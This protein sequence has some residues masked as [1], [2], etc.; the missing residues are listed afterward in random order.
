M[1]RYDAMLQEYPLIHLCPCCNELGLNLQPAAF[2]FSTTVAYPLQARFPCWILQV[3]H[4]CSCY[5]DLGVL[6]ALE[7]RTWALEHLHWHI[8]WASKRYGLAIWWPS[9]RRQQQ[10]LYQDHCSSK[11]GS[12]YYRLDLDTSLAVGIARLSCTEAGKH[13]CGNL[14]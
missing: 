1:V 6:P 2:L 12:Q 7:C 13:P 11:N 4:V 3:V 5:N 8:S 14:G 9:S 10:H